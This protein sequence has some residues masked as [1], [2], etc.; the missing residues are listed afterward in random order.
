MHQVDRKASEGSSTLEAFFCCVERL[1]SGSDPVAYG[2]EWEGR[3]PLGRGWAGKPKI[4]LKPTTDE[5]GVVGFSVH[6]VQSNRNTPPVVTLNAPA[7]AIVAQ[8]NEALKRSL[9]S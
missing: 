9:F 7:V 3:G 6:V 5:N 4:V 8:R 1:L 2:L